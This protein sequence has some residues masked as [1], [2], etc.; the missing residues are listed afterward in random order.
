MIAAAWAAIG[1]GVETSGKLIK[2]RR[3]KNK[4][5]DEGIL[6]YEFSGNSNPTS[7]GG[8]KPIA[9][10]M[11]RVSGYQIAYTGPKETKSALYMVSVGEIKGPNTSTLTDPNCIFAD[12]N[13]G[14][15]VSSLRT[16]FKSGKETQEPMPG[17]AGDQ[18]VATVDMDKLLRE[19]GMNQINTD[20]L[21]NS[22][23]AV[24]SGRFPFG[25]YEARN[26][27][28]DD[29]D[30][31][32]QNIF[33]QAKGN[34]GG[35]VN[36]P[37]VS[38][39]REH[40]RCGTLTFT[41]TVENPTPDEDFDIRAG[42]QWR[43]ESRGHCVDKN[44]Y[45]SK[46]NIRAVT[47]E[48]I[49][50]YRNGGESYNGSAY[51]KVTMTLNDENRGR[52]P[53]FS[54]L[55]RG[56][57]VDVPAQNGVLIYNSPEYETDSSQKELSS[58]DDLGDEEWDQ[59][60]LPGYTD[61]PVLLVYYLLTN[62]SNGIKGRTK[63]QINIDLA[64]FFEA[65]KYN[66]E[67]IDDL[68]SPTSEPDVYNK[69]NRYTFN[70]QMVTQSEIWDQCNNILASCRAQLFWYGD[71][72]HIYQ[73]RIVSV[74]SYIHVDD[75]S[76]VDVSYSGV[77][78]NDMYTDITVSFADRLNKWN[79]STISISAPAAFNAS[80]HVGIREIPLYLTGV[81]NESQA[82]RLALFELY[83]S[84]TGVRILNSVDGF[85]FCELIVGFSRSDSVKIGS[86]IS[87]ID[88]EIQATAMLYRV[89]NIDRIS[90]S[91][92]KLSMSLY[93]STKYDDIEE[94]TPDQPTDT[95]I[96]ITKPNLEDLYYSPSEAG[97][98][99]TSVDIIFTWKPPRLEA[100]SLDPKPINPD[101]ISY[102]VKWFSTR[103]GSTEKFDSGIIEGVKDLGFTLPNRYLYASG[104]ASTVE[105]YTFQVLAVYPTGLSEYTTN[106]NT[107]S[108]IQASYAIFSPEIDDEDFSTSSVKI[109]YY[110]TQNI[111]NAALPDP[112]FYYE[113][114]VCESDTEAGD[115]NDYGDGDKV[116]KK[117]RFRADEAVIIKDDSK[118]IVYTQDQNI[119][120]TVTDLGLRSL[121][122]LYRSVTRFGR[123]S[124]WL[125]QTVFNTV[126]KKPSIEHTAGNTSAMI[127]V[128]PHADDTYDA[129]AIWYKR[130]SDNDWIR[131][132]NFNYDVSADGSDSEV[133]E[134]SVVYIEDAFGNNQGVAAQEDVPAIGL[135]VVPDPLPTG[136]GW[137]HK[138][139]S[140][141][142]EWKD[143]YLGDLYN[144]VDAVTPGDLSKTVLLTPEDQ[145]TDID[146]DIIG[147]EYID[148]DISEI[149]DMALVVD[150]VDPVNN[151]ITY[152]THVVMTVPIPDEVLA[153]EGMVLTVKS[154]NGNGKPE[155][156]A[157]KFRNLDDIDV[158]E[159]V[160]NTK[161]VLQYNASDLSYE[162]VEETAA[163]AS[164]SSGTIDVPL[165][166][167]SGSYFADEQEISVASFEIDHHKLSVIM[168]LQIE[169]KMV[170]MVDAVDTEYQFNSIEDWKIQVNVRADVD[171]ALIARSELANLHFQTG[172][173]ADINSLHFRAG[174]LSGAG[175][176]VP[177]NVP[178]NVP[179]IRSYTVNIIAR[180]NG[181]F[182]ADGGNLGNRVMQND[183]FIKRFRRPS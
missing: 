90:E 112:I 97:E 53:T 117:Y 50:T 59:T 165:S 131:S 33:F 96:V 12:E 28:A 104:D 150:S 116:Y 170:S 49:Q 81:T 37:T 77:N 68:T 10:G 176:A 42:I 174:T 23:Y 167:S 163:V 40:T 71:T 48:N 82:V 142:E 100:S 51:H 62:V 122:F 168:N 24:V 115:V 4:P 91:E 119:I 22:T 47:I 169:L 138:S 3:A 25:L 32:S 83:D 43:D 111:F 17:F 95:G 13:L 177:S 106:T 8:P 70:Y 133:T 69:I 178:S 129:V 29:E 61:D 66:C 126:P 103:I 179:D 16:D 144:V 80:S 114:L 44:D 60:F 7:A 128:H 182:Q 84:V 35:W 148:F 125:A 109:H 145:A 98:V 121:A 175:S 139:G 78:L 52:V 123:H 58:L 94:S 181:D 2:K 5:E 1:W 136:E 41:A 85:P 39:R 107:V 75:K 6:D 152:Q 65:I 26:N 21:V 173:V 20:S 18:P 157:P 124:D 151:E 93:V 76:F 74:D 161:Y 15:S 88:E 31:T 87:L 11:S 120:D 132:L 141:T 46:Q 99:N 159:P 147:F 162:L 127:S 38:F 146:G 180:N 92:L 140:G 155:W 171:Q 143:I 137:L 108:P 14:G 55:D 135:I 154:D 183:Y 54:F 45:H 153:T 134:A 110:D 89:N 113:F 118:L 64:S 19:T 164:D 101:V 27:V 36:A 160:G 30:S 172:N 57:I 86:V 79:Q 149:R 72:I 56:I 63:D 73:D 158:G 130:D 166:L 105:T 34:S 9:F 156:Q 102:T 67:S